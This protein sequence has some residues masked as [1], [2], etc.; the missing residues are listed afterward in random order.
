[1]HIRHGVLPT[2][3]YRGGE[4]IVNVIFKPETVESVVLSCQTCSTFLRGRRRE[5]YSLP[6]CAEKEE[7]VVKLLYAAHLSVYVGVCKNSIKVSS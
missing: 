5:R 4:K 6:E 7:E 1:M 3:T 2:Y